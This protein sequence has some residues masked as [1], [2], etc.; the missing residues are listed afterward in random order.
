[1]STSNLTPAQLAK[2]PALAAPQGSTPNFTPLYTGL[3]SASFAIVSVWLV[4]VTIIVAARMM[5]KDFASRLIQVEDFC[6]TYNC[7][8]PNSSPR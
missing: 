7:T 5:V 3:Q 4:L 2:L 8:D 1:M 6:I